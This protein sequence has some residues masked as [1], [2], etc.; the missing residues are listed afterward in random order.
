MHGLTWDS[1]GAEGKRPIMRAR[2][3]RSSIKARAVVLLCLLTTL[4][5][6]A[7]G[8]SF[9]DPTASLAPFKASL[10][11]YLGP[12]S[13]GGDVKVYTGHGSKPQ[14]YVRDRVILVEGKAIS[15]WNT[16]LPAALRAAT[17]N[18][19]GT[20]VVVKQ[21]WHKVGKYSG[22]E[23]ALQDVWTISVVDLATGQ[24]VG[25]AVLRGDLPPTVAN[26]DAGENYGPPPSKELF[27]YLARLP[28]R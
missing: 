27:A 2:A 15:L 26:I 8:G 25:R 10:A 9:E 19:V 14:G 3:R 18:D 7:C 6:A 13:G 21:S 12:F 23:P 20:V 4:A 1:R 28:R 11:Q 5:L 22:G 24:V 17:P 16:S